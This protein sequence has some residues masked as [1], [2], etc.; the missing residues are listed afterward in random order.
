MSDVARK[1]RR[2]MP[3]RKMK[4]PTHQM[5]EQAKTLFQRWF[6]KHPTE[7]NPSDLNTQEKFDYA[8]GMGFEKHR[9]MEY[10]RKQ[11]AACTKPEYWE[12]EED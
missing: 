7:R 5:C 10:L 3:R 11:G 2:L 1:E 12:S 9:T 4:K 8:M 6:K